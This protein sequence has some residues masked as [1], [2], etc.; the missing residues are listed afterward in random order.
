VRGI[1]RERENLEISHGGEEEEQ[2]CCDGCGLKKKTLDYDD[3]D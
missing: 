2:E 3:I 1:E